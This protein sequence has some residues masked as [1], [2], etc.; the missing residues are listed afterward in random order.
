MSHAI[1]REFRELPIGL[2]DAPELPARTAMDEAKMD[3]LVTSI[4]AI[5]LIQPI[6]VARVGDRYRVIAGHRRRVA[7]ERAGLVV[8][9]CMVYPSEELAHEA[10][11]T[12]ENL[13][14][15]ELNAADEAIYYAELLEAKC[16]GDVDQLCAI[17]RRKR[18]YVE[19]RL[20]LFQG[21]P[22]VFAKLRNGEITIGVAHELN[23]CGDQAHRRMFLE[24]AIR[25]GA[26]IPVVRSWVDDWKRYAIEVPTGA[27]APAQDIPR[28]PVQ[29][30]DFFKCFVCKGGEHV[31]TMRP[32]N[33]HQHCELAVLVPALQQYQQRGTT[34]RF[35]RTIDE[36][37]ELAGE[38]LDAFPELAAADQ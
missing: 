23:K 8:V 34:I 12:A 35:P 1:D 5:G 6:S 24:Q 22:E 3:D 20:L 9:P 13:D 15:E 18:P 37:R 30:S 29:E 38:I 11:K 36:A 7:S 26:T 25:G 31:H 4:R 10:I 17:V 19:G 2:I 16:S 32:V 27:P 21:D 33:I 28:G 14:R